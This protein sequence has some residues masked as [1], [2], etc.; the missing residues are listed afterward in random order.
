M[1]GTVALLVLAAA[2]GACRSPLA[3]GSSDVSAARSTAE[4]PRRGERIVELER[5]LA[6]RA[7]RAPALAAEIAE[8]HALEALDGT[9]AQRDA[10][11]VAAAT[12]AHAASADLPGDPRIAVLEALADSR[13][14]FRADAT[15]RLSELPELRSAQ[16]TLLLLERLEIERP[17]W[18]SILAAAHERAR[19]TDELEAYRFAILAL[20][21]SQR[22]GQTLPATEERRLTDW[23]LRGAKVEFVC[24]ESRTPFVPGLTRSPISGV[25]HLD[26]VAVERRRP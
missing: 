3:R 26:Y 8:L 16:A 12:Y 11:W 21:G 17:L 13:L 14:G 4:T 19:A 24:P 2:L 9:P 6:A 10:H 25:P 22:F 7:T 20:E 23:V 1:R 5:A 15:R 18:T